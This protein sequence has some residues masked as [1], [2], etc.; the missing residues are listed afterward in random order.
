MRVTANMSAENSLYNIQQGRAKLDRLQELTAS[1]ANVNRP[2]DDPINTRLLLD[3][4]DKLK[5]GAQYSSNIQKTSTW[6][7][8]TYTALTGMSDAVRLAKKLVSSIVNGSSD[9]TERQSAH[10]QLVALKQQM[11]DMGNT[12]MGDQY[13][14]GGA[15]NTKPFNYSV[16]ASPYYAGDET[17]QNIEVGANSPIKMNVL[18]NQVLAA[19]EALAT[20]YGTVNVLKTF[21]DLIA[22]VGD[23]T[24]PSNVANIKTASIA[25]SDGAQQINN[26]ISD[27]AARLSRLDNAGKMNASIKNTLET[28]YSNTQNVDYAKLAVDMNQQKLAFDASL[29]ATAK[30]SQMSLLDY[31]K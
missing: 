9:P 11:V 19:D 16:T 17:Q 13:L 14:F 12:Q 1:G 2:S 26:A 15:N 8:F 3:I 10:D 22:A 7:Q 29:S 20:P 23:S 24:N 21:D 25:L 31:L 28:V 5:A 6:Q 30:L 4:G 18:G 27:V